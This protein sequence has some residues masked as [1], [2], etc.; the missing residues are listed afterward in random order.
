MG[1]SQCN[2]GIN[3]SLAGIGSNKGVYRRAWQ[4]GR[5]AEGRHSGRWEKAGCRLPHGHK[6]GRCGIAG[7]AQKVEGGLNNVLGSMAC[8]H[9]LVIGRQLAEMQMGIGRSVGTTV[10]HASRPAHSYPPPRT[11]L[12]NALVGERKA[13]RQKS[14]GRTATATFAASYAR[15]VVWVK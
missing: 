9:V 14:S 6:M 8:R 10:W 2:I 4:A 5:E 15:V 3:S 11:V 1:I 13:G 7:V 12:L